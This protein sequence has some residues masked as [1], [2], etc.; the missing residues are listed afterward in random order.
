[1]DFKERLLEYS[2]LIKDEIDNYL[3]IAEVPE[4]KL[5]EAMRYSLEAGGKRIRPALIFEGYRLFADD[6]KSA[7]PFAMAIEMVHTFSLIH[8]DLPAID[9]DDY[10]RG[11][12]TNHKVFGENTAILAGDGLLNLAYEILAKS[13]DNDRKINAFKEFSMAVG[14]MIKGEFVDVDCE[15]KNIDYDTLMYMHHNKTGAL[16]KGAIKIGALLAGADEL[17]LKNI[18]KYADKI[19]ITFQIKDDLLSQNGDFKKLGKPI[20]SDEKNEKSTFVTLLGEDVANDT[21][22][23][24]TNEAVKITETFGEKGVFFKDLAIFIKDREY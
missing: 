13:I 5:L 2:S 24:L 7:L 14:N 3:A 19:G 8:D 11:K 18:E 1:M 12:L 22:I 16:L 6:Y 21:L 23:T 9:N 4:K 17:S 20:G 10:R 15:G